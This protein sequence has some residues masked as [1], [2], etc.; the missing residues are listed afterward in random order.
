LATIPQRTGFA[1]AKSALMKYSPV[2]ATSHSPSQ[3]ARYDKAMRLYLLRS[4]LSPI[5]S[6]RWAR[7]ISGYHRAYKAGPPPSR[8]LLKPLRSYV[9]LRLGPMGRFELLCGHYRLFREI[10]SPVCVQ[11]VCRGEAIVAAELA[12]RKGSVYCLAIAAS[13]RVSM[14]REGELAI[15]LV[16]RGVEAPVSKLSLAFARVDGRLAMLIGGLQGPSA[17]HKRDVIDA[18]RE[19][20]GLRPKDATLLA[21]RALAKA[22]GAT[23]VHAVANRNHVLDRLSGASRLADYD[24]YWRERGAAPGGPLGFVF[25]PLGEV[26]AEGAGRGAFK[27]EIVSAMQR[28]VAAHSRAVGA[29]A[30]R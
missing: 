6:T 19:L 2:F 3:V 24:A 13:T 26:V 18:T 5:V 17:G 23:S 11:R 9:H 21:A 22:V 30:L 16:K 20:H 27:A 28:F 7:F 8:V 10:F 14:Q 1:A 4:L 25:P 29:R 12:A 15:F